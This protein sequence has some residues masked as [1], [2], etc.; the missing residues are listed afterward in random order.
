MT[1]TD[2]FFVFVSIWTSMTVFYTLYIAAINLFRDWGSMPLWIRVA[3]APILIVMVLTDFLAQITLFTLFFFD[4]PKE[5]MV[6]QR[7]ERYRL[8]S[9]YKGTWRE[10]IAT[11]ICTQALNPFDPTRHHC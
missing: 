11:V 9:E 3:S 2:F 7:L 1:A 6:T 10:R 5:F 8:D 4:L